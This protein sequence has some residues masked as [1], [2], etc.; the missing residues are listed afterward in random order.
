MYIHV[1]A[2]FK[3]IAL[4]VQFATLRR[5]IYIGHSS[6]LSSLLLTRDEHGGTNEY[7]PLYALN[8]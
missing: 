4:A 8:H 7:F 1:F 2:L 5:K 6:K 3:F